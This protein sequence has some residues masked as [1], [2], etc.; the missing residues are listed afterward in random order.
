MANNICK[1]RSGG[2]IPRG[3]GFVSRRKTFIKP[4]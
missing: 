2:F 3:I 1:Y 4:L